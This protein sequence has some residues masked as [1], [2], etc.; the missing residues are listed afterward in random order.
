MVR[1]SYGGVPDPRRQ[2][3]E[4]YPAYRALLNMMIECRPMG[5]DYVVLMDACR[6]LKGAAQHF[7]RDPNIYG[8][9]PASQPEG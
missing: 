4:L 8:G 2:F 3:G 9:S 7:T 1:R 5:P 6:A